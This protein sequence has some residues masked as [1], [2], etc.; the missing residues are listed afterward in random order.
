[1]LEVVA[2]VLAT[3]VACEARV[4]AATA[5]VFTVGN[6]H[7]DMKTACESASLRGEKF[8][9]ALAMF[10]PTPPPAPL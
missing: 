8:A 6:L 4:V 3:G 7:G 1:M 9:Y 10:T 2:G 5:V